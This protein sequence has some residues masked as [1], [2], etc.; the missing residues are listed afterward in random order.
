MSQT[1]QNANDLMKL[2]HAKYIFIYVVKAWLRLK[3]K[4]SFNMIQRNEFD[5]YNQPRNLTHPVG[6]LPEKQIAAK[7]ISGK[8]VLRD[9]NDYVSTPDIVF[10]RQ[11]TASRNSSNTTK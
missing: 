11:R 6:V 3:V 2:F 10:R 9:V 8:C 4:N 1:K 5:Q 7:Y